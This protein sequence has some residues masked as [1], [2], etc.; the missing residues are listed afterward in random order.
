[1]KRENSVYGDALPKNILQ[2]GI[3]CL[4][5]CFMKWVFIV[6]LFYFCWNVFRF[7]N[8][9]MNLHI[10]SSFITTPGYYN[11]E[12]YHICSM[13]DIL[14]RWKF[15]ALPEATNYQN[16]RKSPLPADCQHSFRS[17]PSLLPT[18]SFLLVIISQSTTPTEASCFSRG[19]NGTQKPRGHAGL[20]NFRGSALLNQ[21]TYLIPESQTTQ[22]R[23]PE[24]KEKIRGKNTWWAKKNSEI[25]TYIHNFPQPRCLDSECKCSCTL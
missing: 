14:L 20:K 19:H 21:R 13:K 16:S 11:T 5:L 25:G 22:A 12:K 1:M 7:V 18:T 10:I 17:L 8:T 4:L 2:T 15:H 6:F 23:R 24:R 9:S 3:T